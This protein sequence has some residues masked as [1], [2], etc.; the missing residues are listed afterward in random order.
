MDDASSVFDASILTGPVANFPVADSFN[1]RLERDYSTGDSPHVFVA[2]AVW[3]LPLG[4]CRRTR[5]EGVFEAVVNDWTVTGILTLQ[6]EAPL[7]VTQTTN[8]NAFAR[9]G[10]QRLSLVGDPAPPADRGAKP[11]MLVYNVSADRPDLPMAC[12]ASSPTQTESRR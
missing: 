6:S 8:N 7:A 3:D 5:A 12:A 9:F 4:A 1:R 10:T 11:S 2:S